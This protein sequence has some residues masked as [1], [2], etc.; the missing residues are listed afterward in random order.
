MTAGG[1]AVVSLY[2]CT[3]VQACW[4]LCG[5]GDFGIVRSAGEDREIQHT[6]MKIRKFSL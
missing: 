6:E 4:T 2:I 5:A 1:C 3:K